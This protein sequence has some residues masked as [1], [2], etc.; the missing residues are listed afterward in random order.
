MATEIYADYEAMSQAA[1]AHLKQVVAEK[2][3]A[4]ICLATGSSPSRL[5]EIL[6][7]AKQQGDFQTDK[8]RLLALDEW[9][10]VPR[11]H[12]CTCA[13]FLQQHI[14]EQWGINPEQL[15]TFNAEADDAYA[16]CERIQQYLDDNGPIDV[17]ILGLGQNGHLGLNEPAA[18]LKPDVHV[19]ELDERSQGHAMLSENG[20]EVKQGMTIGL[21]GILGSKEIM[22]L[23]TGD[24][25][26]EV[27]QFL[28]AGQ[29][30]T[31][32]PASFLHVHPNVE[33]FIDEEI[34]QGD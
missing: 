1:A 13:F 21:S 19:A 9:Y 26:E 7:V 10:G 31:S 20:V 28:L 8:L 18:T 14:V 12:P 32:I 5:Y 3:D 2:P 6:A 23:I 24:D 29:I 34:D 33:T 25:K 27:Y 15:T 16:E 22:M 17:C 11:L 4:L 30:S